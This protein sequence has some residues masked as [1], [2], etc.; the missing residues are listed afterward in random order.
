MSDKLDYKVRPVETGDWAF[1][2]H[3]WKES[4]RDGLFL[5]WSW[6]QY[7]RDMNHAIDRLRNDADVRW[8][9]ACDAED[10]S[11]IFGWICYDWVLSVV[12]YVYIKQPYRR[13]GIA[14]ELLEK[15]TGLPSPVTCFY[16]FETRSLREIKVTHTSINFVLKGFFSG[17]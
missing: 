9:V 17:E 6:V 11:C 7:K 10:P 14:K 2:Y 12:H 4:L 3:S 15:R 8:L 1:I 5:H 16:S 13:Q